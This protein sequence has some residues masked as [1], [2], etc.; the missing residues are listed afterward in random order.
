MSHLRSSGEKAMTTA[1]IGT[2]NIGGQVARHLVAGGEQAILAARDESHA[3]ALATEVGPLAVAAPV[4][5]AVAAADAVV[6]GVWLDASKGL[7]S[8]N[9]DLLN[10]KV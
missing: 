3:V 4:R 5:P 2:G 1:I 7:S 6:L 10:G 8:E 9:G